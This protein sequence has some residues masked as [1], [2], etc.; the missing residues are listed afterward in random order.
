ML[1]DLGAKK[2]FVRSIAQAKI[3]DTIHKGIV[4][5]NASINPSGAGAAGAPDHGAP[6]ATTAASDDTPAGA[7]YTPPSDE[8]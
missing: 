7:V 6:D 3:K 4:K 8:P 1:E 5:K 2:E